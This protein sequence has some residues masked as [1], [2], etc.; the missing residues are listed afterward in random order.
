MR[1]SLIIGFRACWVRYGCK[2]LFFYGFRYGSN[3]FILMSLVIDRNASGIDELKAAKDVSIFIQWSV[4]ASSG[5]C[6]HLVFNDIVSLWWLLTSADP[7]ILRAVP[8]GF[9]FRDIGWPHWPLLSSEWFFV[10]LL[11]ITANARS[12][13]SS[14]L[15]LPPPVLSVCLC[16]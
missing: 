10:S 8:R 12:H 16:I 3:R 7:L 9:A 11:I 15:S 5:Q 2:I 6:M 14:Y 4:Y 13:L 1:Q